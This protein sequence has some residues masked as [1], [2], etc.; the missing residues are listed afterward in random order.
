VSRR[1]A[2]AAWIAAF[3]LI[4]GFDPGGANAQPVSADVSIT[5]RVE[6]AFA[7]EPALR[8]MRIYVE[9]HDGVVSLTGFVRSVDDIENAGELARAVRGVMAVR[10]ALRVANRPTR[11]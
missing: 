9:T 11:A 10:N 3:L 2:L 8:G 5:Q 1:A 4:A 6:R 7:S